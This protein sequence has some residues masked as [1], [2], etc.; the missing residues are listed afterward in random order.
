VSDLERM[1]SAGRLAMEYRRRRQALSPVDVTEFFLE[2]VQ[3]I[4]PKIKSMVTVTSDL[5]RRQA[6][7]AARR[8]ADGDPSPLLGVPILVKDLIDVAGIRTT[9]GSAVLSDNVAS[10]S[11]RVWQLLERAGAVLVGKAN[12]HEFAYG[13][14]TEPTVNPWDTNRLVG[15]SSGGPAAGLAAGLAPLALGTDTAG[16]VRIP[17][18]LCGVVGLKPTNGTVSARGVIPLA[19]SLDIV[20]PMG[21]HPED[22]AAV[23]HVIGGTRFAA[24]SSAALTERSARRRLRFGYLENPGPM[25]PG[26]Q[27]A[28]EDTIA[29]ASRLGTVE[30]ARL[31][32]FDRSVFVNFAL[33]G[34]EAV[35]VHEQW[36]DR[37]DLYSA[38]VRERLEQAALTTAVDYERAR[39]TASTYR[40]A[41]DTIF[42]DVDVLVVPGVPFA[43]PKLGATTVRVGRTTEDRDTAM[44]RNTGFA[45]VTGHP[46]LA[47]PAGAEQGL[48]VG[49]QLVAARGTDANLLAVGGQVWRHLSIV[50]VAPRW[51]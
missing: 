32:D 15:G 45:N 46:A 21:H 44:C 2:R 33:L 38:Y 12:T 23:M 51:Q 11:A 35:F 3:R 31:D 26:V 10:R 48:P 14:T 20:G 9:A 37:R 18:N 19:P 36:S 13:G 39:R 22:L 34:V 5:A 8:I 29:V 49:V 30:R 41:V 1:L 27:R 6:A 24:A 40:A 4:D 16:S 17:A 43:A 25:S 47:L 42:R 28:F 50:T 7:A